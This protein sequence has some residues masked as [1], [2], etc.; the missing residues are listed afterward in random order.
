M[1][2]KNKFIIYILFVTSILLGFFLQ[3]NAS[4]GA[5]IDYEFFKPFIFAFSQDFKSGLDLFA[6]NPGSFIHSPFF[7]IMVGYL[8]KVLD[9][10][11]VVQILYILVC[12]TLP[13][14]IYLILKT[15]YKVNYEYLFYISLI[16]FF[17]IYFRSS[18]IWLLG[19]NLSIL[20]FSLSVLFF[21]KTFENNK[22]I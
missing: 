12:S 8:F 18:A 1:L 9:N 6:N 20:F 21:L 17:S 19:D 3:E 16:I 15:K 4:G 13:Y 7:Y 22:I 10:I 11:F 14:I 2:L 5:K